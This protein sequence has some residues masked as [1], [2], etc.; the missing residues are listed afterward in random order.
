MDGLGN[1]VGAGQ[2]KAIGLEIVELYVSQLQ[3]SFQLLCISLANSISPAEG[4]EPH[5]QSPEQSRDQRHGEAQPLDSPMA[6]QRAS[7]KRSEGFHPTGDSG[8]APRKPPKNAQR[9]E[10]GEW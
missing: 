5:Q 4:L 6:D 3:L 8:N 1:K 9:C 10:K 2:S 7:P